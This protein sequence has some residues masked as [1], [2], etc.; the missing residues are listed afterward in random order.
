[1]ASLFAGAIRHTGLRTAV[2]MHKSCQIAYGGLCR[3]ALAGYGTVRRNRRA[4]AA[5]RQR[6]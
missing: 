5:Q 2:I 1:M 4:G 3:R 6:A